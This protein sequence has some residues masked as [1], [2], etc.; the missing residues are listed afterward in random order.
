MELDR[1]HEAIDA[2]AAMDA[3]SLADEESVVALHHELSRLEAVTTGATGAFERAGTWALT[4]ARHLAAW[5]SVRCGLSKAESRRRVRLGRAVESLP[6]AAQAWHEGEITGSH[7]AKLASLHNARTAEALERDEKV[8]VDQAKDLS[9]ADF[10][11]VA[12]Y[13]TYHADQD[14]AEDAA[15]MRRC[16]RDAF[17][18]PSA[19]RTWL[20]SMNLDEISGVIVANEWRAREQA[21]FEADRAEFFERTGTEATPGDLLCRTAAQRRADAL[22]EM[23]KRSAACGSEDRRPRPLFS[24]LVGYETLC[25]PICEL[26]Q[27]MAVTPGSLVPWLSEADI[28][29][30][31]FTP[32]NRVEVSASARLFT[33]AT[34]R[35][36]EIR[37]RR[38][39]H[40]YCDVPAEECQADHVQEWARGGPTT[41]ENG[42]LLC[43]YHNRLRNHGPPSGEDEDDDDDDDDDDAGEW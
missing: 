36:L 40:P 38:C 7:V 13:W 10:C 19:F 31:V 41:Q 23:A 2:L 27:G 24:V 25:G 1:L 5:L 33:G 37:D 9:F 6:V 18:S 42:R 29:R 26:A 14:G 21:L 16:R 39:T 35:A 8:L 43:G 4:G 34:R 17:L 3:E 28:E 30:A 11:R 20:G 12:D 22:V 15:E 32:P